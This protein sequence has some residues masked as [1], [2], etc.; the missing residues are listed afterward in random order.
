[1]TPSYFVE[2][3]KN[4]AIPPSF[5]AVISGLPETKPRPCT[6]SYGRTG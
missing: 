6:S 1:M 2:R 3:G 4:R 5:P